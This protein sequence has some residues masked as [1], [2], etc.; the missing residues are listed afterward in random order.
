MGELA[1]NTEEN[2]GSEMWDM[3]EIIEPE[4]EEVSEGRGYEPDLAA[5]RS[6]KAEVGEAGEA[7]AQSPEQKAR[8][9]RKL[10]R[11]AKILMRPRAQTTSE[12]QSLDEIQADIEDWIE[13]YNGD[14]ANHNQLKNQSDQIET[15][16]PKIAHFAPHPESPEGPV[17]HEMVA[18][19]PTEKVE[20]ET[21]ALQN[22]DQSMDKTGVGEASTNSEATASLAPEKVSAAPVNSEMPLNTVTKEAVPTSDARPT[23][24]AVP[25]GSSTAQN[26][27]SPQ[28][29][30][31]T[32]LNGNAPEADLTKEERFTQEVEF[33]AGE[34]NDAERQFANYQRLAQSGKQAAERQISEA[35]FHDTLRKYEADQAYNW[36]QLTGVT[37]Q[38]Q[39]QGYLTD[40]YQ[41]ARTERL[42]TVEP[43][44]TI[45]AATGAFYHERALELQQA[46]RAGDSTTADAELTLI[47][48]TLAKVSEYMLASSDYESRSRDLPLYN[49]QRRFAHNGMIRQLNNLNAL[50]ERYQ[51]PRFTLRDF[52]TNDFKYFPHLDRGSHLNH[53]AEYDRET[54]LEYFRA[55][56][57]QDF[58]KF[59]EK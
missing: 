16:G 23:N 11:L 13:E 54:V 31:N 29:A 50:S 10:A 4:Q 18:N 58:A 26:P 8:T 49:V 30:Q 37:G 24:N 14:M 32:E 9:E 12:Q 28:S 25:E 34:Y 43:S 57:S 51:T 27:Q 45:E 53:R 17:S 35:D 44:E 22:E 59:S 7:E 46:I 20:N 56:F 38:A 19:S 42:G 48:Q 52:M 47:D 5:F 3:G 21:D 6:M 2:L 15:T 33:W 1:R 39:N 55:A 41:L 36:R 40:K